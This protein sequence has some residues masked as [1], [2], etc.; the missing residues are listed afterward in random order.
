MKEISSN[1]DLSTVDVIYPAVPLYLYLGPE[2]F[3][4]V[5]LPIL[6]YANHNTNKYGEGKEYNLE[7]APH[8]IGV[9]PIADLKQEDQ[10]NMP[11]EETGNMLQLVLAIVQRTGNNLEWLE[12]Y[13]PLLKQWADYLVKFLPDPGDQLCTD[14]FMGPS[15]HNIN[16]AIKGIVGIGAYAELLKLKGDKEVAELYESFTKDF[17]MWYKKMGY[18]SDH[19]RLQYNLPDTWSL[20]YNMVFQNVLGLNIFSK[21]DMQMEADYY[22]KFHLNKYGVPL[23]NRATFTKVCRVS[24]PPSLGRLA[25]VGRLHGQRGPAQRHHP[26]PLPLRPRDSLQSPL[27][28]L[29]PDRRRGQGRRLQSQTRHGRPLHASARYVSA[30]GKLSSPNR[31]VVS[32]HPAHTPRETRGGGRR[33]VPRPR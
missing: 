1:G 27:Q 3:Q 15:P 26:Q 4:K 32:F 30:F 16:L 19:S 18:D 5:L 23:D 28:R 20:K 8:H 14:D 33:P 25:H 13:W 2:T 31:L 9:W 10:E 6:E 29:V 7:W 24:P 17:Y 22:N 11:V 12:P 21:E